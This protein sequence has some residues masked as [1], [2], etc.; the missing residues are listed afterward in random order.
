MAT[1]SKQPVETQCNQ[2][3]FELSKHFRRRVSAR[4]D[5]GPISSDGGT[6]LLL[7]RLAGYFTDRRDPE[8]IEHSVREL[9]SQR[10]DGQA[11]GYEDLNDHDQL[12]HDPLPA[13][14]AGK[15]D[16]IGAGRK[17]DRDRGKALA[18]KSRL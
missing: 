10:V 18:G 5:G 4:F 16:P 17:R 7:E 11:P 1:K 13:V 9:V 12:R 6:V 2:K 8:R 15:T 14:A 3:S